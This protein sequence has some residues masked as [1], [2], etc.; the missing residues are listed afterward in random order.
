[1]R[2][3]GLVIGGDGEVHTLR[4]GDPVRENTVDRALVVNFL[5]SSGF[6]YEEQYS[7]QL[8]PS[9]FCYH[10]HGDSWYLC[11]LSPS[12]IHLFTCSFISLLFWLLVCVLVRMLVRPPSRFACLLVHPC[13]CSLRSSVSVTHFRRCRL[14]ACRATSILWFGRW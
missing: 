10:H 8:A 4:H 3:I 11:K 13:C 14:C 6:E 2:L 1:M 12:F 9:T 7:K 5:V